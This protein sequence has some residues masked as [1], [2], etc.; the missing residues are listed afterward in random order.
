MWLNSLWIYNHF[1]IYIY[2]YMYS[3]PDD[4]CRCTC[5][6]HDCTCIYIS[7]IVLILVYIYRKL[8]ILYA[9]CQIE[10][11][12]VWSLWLTYCWS[13]VILLRNVTSNLNCMRLNLDIC[14][15]LL[16]VFIYIIKYYASLYS[17][18]DLLANLCFNTNTHVL[19]GKYIKYH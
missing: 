15:L 8:C 14:V 16:Q 9:C 6:L 18:N 13:G 10:M 11:T 17:I 5:N 3:V 2:I 4:F 7:C 19:S 12:I 1:M